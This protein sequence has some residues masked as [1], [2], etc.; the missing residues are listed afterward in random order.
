MS[1]FL[2]LGSVG[3]SRN[4]AKYNLALTFDTFW[5]L[6]F[7]L[8]LPRREKNR[9]QIWTNKGSEHV[10]SAKD[11]HFVVLTEVR[12]PLGSN[13]GKRVLVQSILLAYHFFARANRF[14]FIS[15]TPFRRTLSL[16]QWTTFS[17]IFWQL[18]M[19][20]DRNIKLVKLYTHF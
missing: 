3:N 15:K 9:E 4:M 8:V 18:V 11:V 16:S 12:H 5:Y 13:A 1:I 7:F 2:E 10:K 19:T 20:L 14:P 6:P 17:C